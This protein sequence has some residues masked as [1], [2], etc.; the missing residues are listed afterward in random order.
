M[1]TADVISGIAVP[2][3]ALARDATTFIRR[4]ED[5]LL[6]DHS[7]R[8]FFFGAQHGRRQEL[9]PD[10]ELLY[11]AAMFHVLSLTEPYRT[12]SSLRFEVDGANAARDFAIQHGVDDNDA[13]TVWMSIA[14]HTTPGVPE[15]LEPEIALLSAG[16]ATDVLGI[17]RDDLSPEELSAVTAGHPRAD[18][19]HRFLQTL[20]V[21]VRHRPRS[22]T[23][24]VNAD[25]LAEYDPS[26]HRDDL[27]QPFSTAPGPSSEEREQPCEPITPQIG[28]IQVQRCQEGFAIALVRH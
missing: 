26:F 21:G 20:T 6:Y 7:R 15:F 19:K 25:V 14:L 1:R 27:S 12:S 17:G 4:V 5:D 10:L 23:G 11:L 16:V 22:A 24:T 13:R 18:F 2:D 3:T 28:Q 9:E 8:V